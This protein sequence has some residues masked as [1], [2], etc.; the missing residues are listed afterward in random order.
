MGYASYLEDIIHRL[1]DALSLARERRIRTL[2]RDSDGK[3][4]KDL[5]LLI[6][7]ARRE[8][9][10]LTRLN[11]VASDGTLDLAQEVIQLK[12]QTKRLEQTIE[13][14]GNGA[15][16]LAEKC[17]RLLEQNEHL[18]D[19]ISRDLV[20]EFYDLDN[21]H[22]ALHEREKKLLKQE[23]RLLEKINAQKEAHAKYVEESKTTIGRLETT[24]HELTNKLDIYE[25]DRHSKLHEI[26]SLNERIQEKDTEIIDLVG[27]IGSLRREIADLEEELRI[28]DDPN[29]AYSRYS[30]DL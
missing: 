27:K 10:R 16:F 30:K 28:R 22:M 29:S 24:I 25:T 21:E 13:S 8:L 2:D 18:N 7:V 5:E 14:F 3:V 9:H 11:D 20:K 15:G 12:A 23:S 6:E 17:T 4:L 19:L 26:E 1:D